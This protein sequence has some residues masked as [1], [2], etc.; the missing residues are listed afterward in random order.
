MKDTI[1]N[2]FNQTQL[3][4]LYQLLGL[5]QLRVNKKWQTLVLL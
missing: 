1:Y 2:E 5:I 3:D 4:N